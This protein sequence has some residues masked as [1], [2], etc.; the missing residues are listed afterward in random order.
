MTGPEGQKGFVTDV[1]EDLMPRKSGHGR[2]HR[3]RGDDESRGGIDPA[4]WIKTMVSLNPLMIDGTGMCGVCRCQ[5]GGKTKFACVDGP[6][7][8][9]HLVDFEASTG[10]VWACLKPR[11]A[12]AWKQGSADMTPMNLN[13]EQMPEQDPQVR[14]H[15]FEEVNLGFTPEQAQRE[16]ARC[17]FCKKPTCVEGCPVHVN[18]PEFHTRYFG[19]PDG[20]GRAQNPRG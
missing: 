8:D 12:R 6:E 16:A 15:N 4:A 14:A 17:L 10:A 1:L 13:R 20:R 18:I 9:A 3:A 11:N 7:F 5:V 2:G 19:K